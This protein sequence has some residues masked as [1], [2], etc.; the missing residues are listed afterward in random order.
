[1]STFKGKM[2]EYKFLSIDRFD[3]ENLAPSPDARAFFLSHCHSDHMEGLDSRA[4]VDYLKIS[5]SKLYTHEITMHLLM[6]DPR[7]IHLENF[8][9]PLKTFTPYTIDLAPKNSLM[10]TLLPA[11]H[12]PGSVM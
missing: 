9:V 1:M 2:F 8:I 3:D 5:G 4:F 6:F 10:V 11:G 12:C 7:Y